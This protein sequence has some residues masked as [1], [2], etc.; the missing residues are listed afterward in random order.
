VIGNHAR[1]IVVLIDANQIGNDFMATIASFWN[2]R[3]QTSASFS[4]P[5]PI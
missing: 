4:F 3:T 5:E 2:S 1:V